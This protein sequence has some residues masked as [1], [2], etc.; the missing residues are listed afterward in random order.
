MYLE[1]D[2]IVVSPEFVEIY[3]LFNVN[4]QIKNIKL[5]EKKELLILLILAVDSFS[6]ENSIVLENYRPF[7]NELDVIYKL[8]ISDFPENIDTID[9]DPDIL[10]ELNELSKLTKDRYID[11]T[12]IVDISGSELPPPL[13]D[14]EALSKR[15]DIGINNIIS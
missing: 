12:K 4:D 5:L 6:E 13:S 9:L 11:T 2:K 3:K 15:R 1:N 10:S 14:E 7:S 8:Q